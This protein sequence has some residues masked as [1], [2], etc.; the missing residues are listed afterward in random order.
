M[1]DLKAHPQK[2]K[3][4]LVPGSVETNPNI[5]TISEIVIRPR[6]TPRF[7]RHL[8]F[9]IDNSSIQMAAVSH[10]GWKKRIL[11]I[12]K[13]YI[14]N[15][16]IGKPGSDDFVSH[17]VNT[18]LIEFGRRWDKVSVTISGKNTAFRTFSMPLLKKRELDSAV[19]FEVKKQ[20]PFSSDDCIY[21]YRPVYKVVSDRQTRYKVALQASTRR[22]IDDVLEPFRQRNIIV[23]AVHHTQDVIGQLLR[24]LPD[25]REETYYTVINI[26]R[27][28]SEISYYRG[29]NLEFFH[30]STTGSSLLSQQSD[31]A[32]YETIAKTLSVEIQTSL[33]YY[34]GQYPGSSIDKIFVY[35][36]LAYYDE[37]LELLN[38]Y[39]GVEFTR[40]PAE[41]LAFVSHERCPFVEALP[42]CLPVLASSTCDTRVANLLPAVDRLKLTKR[43]F[44]K[45]AQTLLVLL[46]LALVSGWATMKQSYNIKRNNLISLNRQ[47]EDFKNSEAFHTY[48]LLKQQIAN[49]QVS[50]KKTRK[51]PSYL[52]LNL[53]EL[54][55]LTPSTI[56][57]FDLVYKPEET[58][59]NITIQGVVI[60]K[61]IPP[62]IILAEYVEN[63]N[64]SPFFDNVTIR[65]HI[66]RRLAKA[67]EI[68]FQ[69]DMRGVV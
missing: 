19:R 6:S 35:G 49:Y 33:D 39:T 34:A 46:V 17:T 53:K 42:V 60:S 15:N 68:E 10:F 56:R 23:S 36:D 54:S 30:I 26:D 27:N 40:F 11:D 1:L 38:G 22:F 32:D 58:S 13:V 51:L 43:K 14:P 57:L 16:L 62:E 65:R 63:L 69:I 18:F 7:R 8:S 12:R 67:F 66:K 5:S 9:S 2:L 52:N 24:H 28:H 29:S 41:Q 44:D 47:V 31:N 55:L 61:D 20:V 25:F 21:D 59:K 4:A 64:S 48:K 45:I 37:L 50:I 3:T